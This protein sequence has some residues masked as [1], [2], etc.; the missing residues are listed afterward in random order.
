MQNNTGSKKTFLNILIIS[1]IISAVLAI[2]AF[3]GGSFGGTQLK[4]IL[5]TLA[6]AGFSLTSLC[7]A[8]LLEKLRVCKEMN[9][10]KRLIARFGMICSTLGFILA[11]MLIWGLLSI[12]NML[13]WQVML[14]SIIGAASCSHACLLLHIQ[15][16]NLAVNSS[17]SMTLI[18]IFLVAFMLFSLVVN[19]LKG[20]NITWYRVLG[21]FA[22]LDTLGT[23][24]TPILLKT[25]A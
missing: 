1:L 12:E 18:M 17:L 10:R 22:I 19:G 14:V 15:S 21:V 3:L 8:S 16:K 7:C 13:I 24:I 5:S 4:I 20:E 2:M 23:L 25:T 11:I 9:Q 6:M